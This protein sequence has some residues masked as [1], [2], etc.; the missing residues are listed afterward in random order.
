MPN[1]LPLDES[2]FKAVI[3]AFYISSIKVW[4][5]TLNNYFSNPLFTAGLNQKEEGLIMG[6][7][8]FIL[9]KIQSL[10]QTRSK[11]ESY[12][13]SLNLRILK[14]ILVATEKIRDYI[15]VN[16]FQTRTNL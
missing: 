6:S 2:T 1:I 7:T 14:P 10:C 16:L 13:L 12:F 11:Y 4:K 9:N 15:S 3:Q 8:T 5:E